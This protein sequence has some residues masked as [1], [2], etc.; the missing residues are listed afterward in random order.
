MLCLFRCVGW[1]GDFADMCAEQVAGN[2]KRSDIFKRLVAENQQKAVKAKRK[3][4]EKST[5]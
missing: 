2:N 3:Y 5:R 1:N 4:V